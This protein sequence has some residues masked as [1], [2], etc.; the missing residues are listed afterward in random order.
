A[1]F[2][3]YVDAFNQADNEYY[4]NFIGNEDSWT[5]LSANIPL[6]DCPDKDLERT[7]YFRWWTYRKHIKKTPEGYVITEFLPDVP[8]A[9]KYNTISC[10][11]SQHFYEGRWLRDNTY[12]NDYAK[13]WFKG[14][15]NPRLYSFWAADAIY[16]Q[17]LVNGNPASVKQLLPDLI[18][19]YAEWE[20][21]KLDANGLF[22]QVD[23]RDGMEVS[24]CGS[25]Y[26]PTINAYMYGDA[27]AI[28]KI[29]GV[30]KSEKLSNIYR[31]KA[32]QLK[33]KVQ[34][35]LW[36]QTSNFFKVKPR[37]PNA[38]LC[39]AREL[40]GYTPWY[41]NLPDAEYSRAWQYLT[42]STYFKAPFGP[43][44]VA[45]N[46]VGFKLSYEGHECQWNGPSWPYSTSITLTA[47]A[48][49]LNNY[50]QHVVGRSDYYNL[51][52]TYAVSQQIKD[53]SG[54]LVPWIDENLN[55]LTG[56]WIS[57]TRLKNWV[58][59]TWAK[60]KGG[61]ERGK[62]Y[63]HS[64]FCDLIISGL[65]GLR[66]SEGRQLVINPLVPEGKWDYFC[67]DKILYH[68]KELTI[69]YDKFGTRYKKGKGFMIWVNGQRLVASKVLKR[70]VVNL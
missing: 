54:K 2:K 69:L 40:L 41:F 56:D 36:D 10:P 30:S 26:R 3:H 19:N 46:H 28:S 7:Y 9:G 48:N 22:W 25:G 24:V 8:W 42:D 32:E 29:A 58:N 6:L 43:T 62:D 65:I 27:L 50:N 47:M 12:L 49:L 11:A 1:D 59:G 16:N 13:F 67:L 38:V 61:V 20:K 5:F 15:G 68:D 53:G 52:K 70:V 63:N 35:Q 33:N 60:D 51:I 39:D 21:E 18:S 23:D 31:I 17:Y 4:R 14:G 44:S 55:P 57:R 64:T 45:R 34:N 37:Q 66:P